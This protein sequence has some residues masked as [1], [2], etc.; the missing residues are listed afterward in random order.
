[1]TM[2][3]RLV[4]GFATFLAALLC[5]GRGWCQ[6]TVRITQ[7]E[8]SEAGIFNRYVVTSGAVVFSIIQPPGWGVSHSAEGKSLLLRAPKG[9]GS[10]KAQWKSS[11]ELPPEAQKDVAAWVVSSQFTQA[12]VTDKQP[13]HGMGIDGTAITVRHLVGERHFFVSR[14]GVFTLNGGCLLATY[15]VPE[16]GGKQLDAEWVGLVN[17]LELKSSPGAAGGK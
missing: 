14:V 11:E 9:G 17:S 8:I 15:T 6:S 3:R 1:M 12:T 16:A 4:F 10:L 5:S 7:E 13:C 2:K